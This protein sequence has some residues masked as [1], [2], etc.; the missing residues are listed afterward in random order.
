MIR[1]RPLVARPSFLAATAILNMA[2]GIAVRASD[3]S[4][5]TAGTST[6]QLQTEVLSSLALV[7]AG[8]TN[9]QASFEQRK[10]LA[11]LER[12]I[13]IRG[14]LAVQAPDRLAWHVTA[15]IRFSIVLTGS[16]LQQWDEETTKVQRISLDRN[17]IFGVVARLLRGGLSGDL[18]SLTEDFTPRVLTSNPPQL[19]FIPK[20]TSL[21]AKAVRRIVLTLREDR[22]YVHAILIE[23]LDGDRTDIS[24]SDT[25]L[26]SPIAPAVWEVEPATR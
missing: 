3:T 16:V 20:E 21:A 4:L 22:R 19:E 18:K 9:V 2:A 14:N 7:L 11:L 8:T 24:F 13:V 6:P 25:R 17:P 15:P 23:Q 26:N 1:I 10:H 5:Q 12:E